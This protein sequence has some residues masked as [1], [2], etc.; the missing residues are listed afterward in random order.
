MVPDTLM[1]AAPASVDVFTVLTDGVR[2]EVVDALMTLLTPD[3]LARRTRYVREVDRRTFVITRA[4]VRR[5]LTTHG[6][7]APRDWR[8]ETNRFGCP[9]VIGSQ[10]GTPPL[11]FNLSHTNGLVA[12]AVTRG[13]LV[14]IDVER[15]DRVVHEQIAERYFAPCEVRD[16]HALAAEAQP[17]AFFEYWTLK[18][19]YIKARG[20]G[21]AV[22][23]ADFAFALAPPAPPTIAFAEGF[24]DRPERWRFWQAWPTAIHRLALAVACDGA[25]LSVAHVA[26][27]AD[28]LVP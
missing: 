5:M 9:S 4:L 23:L 13:Y 7:T 26:T 6:P 21:L 24:D 18:E 27:T 14:G 2:D 8:F 16:L 3:E 11:A 17:R 22:P 1:P 15:V 12:L 25:G 19:A 10:A 20:M 28:A